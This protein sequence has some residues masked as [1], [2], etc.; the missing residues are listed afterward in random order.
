LLQNRFAAIVVLS[1]SARRRLLVFALQIQTEQVRFHA[2][3]ILKSSQDGAID[4][5]DVYDLRRSRRRKTGGARGRRATAGVLESINLAPL[6]LPIIESGQALVDGG[7]LNN[8]PANV[9]VAKGCNFVIASTVT[10]KLEQD[11]K[12]IRSKRRS[13]IIFGS[14]A[15]PEY[16]VVLQLSIGVRGVTGAGRRDGRCPSPGGQFEELVDEVNSTPNIS[17]AHPRRTCPFR[18]MFIA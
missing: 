2:A 17:P 16:P 9:L 11:F 10:A 18:I 5:S 7:L 4:S 6:S 13:R 15:H 14:V 1:T 12:G 8:D 3:E